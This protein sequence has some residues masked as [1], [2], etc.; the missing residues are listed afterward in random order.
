M[1][2]ALPGIADDFNHISCQYKPDMVP[3]ITWCQL[4]HASLRDC[5]DS[6]SP[7]VQ[8]LKP[9]VASTAGHG[10]VYNSIDMLIQAMPCTLNKDR[11]SRIKHRMTA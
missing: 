9:L 11:L 5:F 3:Y 6:A 10:Q 4:V 8:A 7:G 2:Q 1:F